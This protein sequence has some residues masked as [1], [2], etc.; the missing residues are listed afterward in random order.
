MPARQEGS[1]RHARN[2]WNRT[3]LNLQPDLIAAVTKP[4]S[5]PRNQQRVNQP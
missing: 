5:N 4:V 2:H 3:K 1:M